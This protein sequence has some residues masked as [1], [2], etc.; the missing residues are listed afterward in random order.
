MAGADLIDP[1]SRTRWAP[2]RRLDGTTSLVDL[3]W[4]VDVTP[5]VPAPYRQR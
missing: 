3:D 5:A 4:I 1:E 2:I